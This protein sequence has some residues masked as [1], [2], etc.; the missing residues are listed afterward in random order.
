MPFIYYWWSHVCGMVSLSRK[1][2][3]SG[4]KKL[5]HNPLCDVDEEAISDMVNEE[6]DTDSDG[7]MD[8]EIEGETVGEESSNKKSESENETSGVSVDGWKEVIMGNKKP[9]AYTFT[10]NAGPQF[11]LL[12]DAEPMDYFSLFYRNKQVCERQNC[13]T[14]AKSEVHLE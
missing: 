7:E 10:K 6:L 2:G 4:F 13:G 9:K 8:L 11:N 12:P 14:S 1:P 5:K 3:P